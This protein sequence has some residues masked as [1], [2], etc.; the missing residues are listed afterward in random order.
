M[1]LLAASPGGITANLYSHLFKGDV[2]LNI[3]LTAIN[4]VLAIVSIP[5]I[6]NFSLG[7][8]M[9]NE[10]Y[11]PLQFQKTLEVIVLI[12]A[13]VAVGMFIHARFPR[14]A[15]KM[16]KPVKIGSALILV[17][18]IAAILKREWASIAIHFEQV[19]VASLLFNIASMAVGYYA[20]KFARLT[21]G[22]SRA[23][24]FEIGI[25]SSTLTIYLALAVLQNGMMAI[26]GAIYGLMMFATAAIF[27]WWVMRA[28]KADSPVI[29]G[30]LQRGV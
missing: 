6:V 4:A 28:S 27:G 3:S 13:P 12:L 25:H 7:S 14:F 21:E 9:T 2:A 11:I 1:M 19:G 30:D 15:Q 23:L 29:A 16:D 18:L 10:Q 26:P 22:Q 5:L 17:L 20:G 24:A 8:F